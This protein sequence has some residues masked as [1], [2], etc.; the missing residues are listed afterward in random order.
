MQVYKY[1]SAN[2]ALSCLPEVGDG[3]LRATPPIALNDPYESFIR[4]LYPD[5]ETDLDERQLVSLLNAI[6]PGKSVDEATIERARRGH[7]SNFV[8]ELFARQL[9]YRYGIVSFSNDFSHP[10]MWSQYAQEGSGFVF[11]YDADGIQ[12]LA[13]A[14]LQKVQYVGNPVLWDYT[15]AQ[16]YDS[17]ALSIMCSKNN[18]WIYENEWRL[19]VEL[20]DTIGIGSEE[21]HGSFIPINL[22]RIPNEI[23]VSVYFAERTPSDIVNTVERRIADTQNRYS[24]A[25]LR[26][27]ILSQSEFAYCRES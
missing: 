18:Q 3:S 25:R 22:V 10:L 21:R 13:S 9:S 7:G 12:C 27:L 1:M 20:K 23:L 11:G 16:L 2:R 6:Y 17:L 8:R 19:I 4:T 15:A 14:V 24:N 5:L 26:K